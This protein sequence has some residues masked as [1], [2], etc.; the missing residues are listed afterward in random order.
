MT[1]SLAV[2][3]YVKKKK[4]WQLAAKLLVMWV[5]SGWGY[6]FACLGFFVRQSICQC[7]IIVYSIMLVEM[8]LSVAIYQHI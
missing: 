4:T 8:S 5:T 7:I 3:N 6:M 2:R 1:H